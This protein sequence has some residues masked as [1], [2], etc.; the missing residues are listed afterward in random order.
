MYLYDTRPKKSNLP[1]DGWLF[2]CYVCREITSNNIKFV[3]KKYYFFKNIDLTM[4]LCKKCNFNSNSLISKD[5]IV[6]IK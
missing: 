3:Y 4:P 1:I 2:P 6:K 5:F